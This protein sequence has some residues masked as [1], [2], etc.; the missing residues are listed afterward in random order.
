MI[1]TIAA[2]TLNPEREIGEYED[3]A[4]KIVGMELVHN[5]AP[6]EHFRRKRAVQ[7]HELALAGWSNADIGK[8]WGLSREMVRKEMNRYNLRVTAIRRR[9]TPQ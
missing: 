4:M 3:A 7:M 9:K 6:G 5:I 8:A 2:T 1:D